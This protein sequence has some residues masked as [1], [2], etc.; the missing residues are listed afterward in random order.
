MVL[1]LFQCSDD[2]RKVNV[3]IGVSQLFESDS[4]R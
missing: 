3:L 2:L 1:I 4:D